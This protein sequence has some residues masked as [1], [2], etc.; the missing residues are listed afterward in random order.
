M[1]DDDVFGSAPRGVGADTGHTTLLVPAVGGELVF[2]LAA[3]QHSVCF[4]EGTEDARRRG[5]LLLTVNTDTSDLDVLNQGLLQSVPLPSRLGGV[6]VFDTEVGSNA[7]GVYPAVGRPI[8]ASLVL[9]IQ[10]GAVRRTLVADLVSGTYA[11]PPCDSVMVSAAARRVGASADRKR[12]LFVA[13]SVT[14]GAVTQAQELIFSDVTELAAAQGV[15]VVTAHVFNAPEGA[16]K[17]RG[18]M[19]Y[20]SGDVAQDVLATMFCRISSGPTTDENSW[21]LSRSWCDVAAGVT[22]LTGVF[23]VAAPPVDWP[24]WS[25]VQWR[26]DP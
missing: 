11:L 22:Y 24:T 20:L 10:V 21:S 1:S 19:L 3:V 12:K 9:D 26:V 8:A 13:A 16:T 4:Y 25:G 5:P 15:N 6:G 17:A 7:W 23:S 14:P 2:P 18:M